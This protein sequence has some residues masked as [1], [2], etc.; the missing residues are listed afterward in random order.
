MSPS[1]DF[2]HVGCEY[3]QELISAHLDGETDVEVAGAIEAHL[4][5]CEVCRDRLDLAARVSRPARL[6][7]VVPWPDV[8]DA[9]LAQAFSTEEIR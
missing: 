2:F 3:D 7:L 8:T 6:G 9:V 5:R 1:S 4:D